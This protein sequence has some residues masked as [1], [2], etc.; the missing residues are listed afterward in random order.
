ME[1]GI[2]EEGFECCEA[3]SF[4]MLDRYISSSDQEYERCLDILNVKRNIEEL[5]W[6]PMAQRDEEVPGRPNSDNPRTAEP[7]RSVLHPHAGA[8]GVRGGPLPQ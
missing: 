8:G 6:N 3:D 1:L 7:I 2:K 4:R 5:P